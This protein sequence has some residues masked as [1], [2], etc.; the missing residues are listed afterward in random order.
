M[1]SFLDSL[2]YQTTALLSID[3]QYMSIERNLGALSQVSEEI[4][5]KFTHNLSHIILPNVQLVHSFCR[6]NG[7]EI[8]HI[9]IQSLTQD[10]R[11]RSL[12]HKRLQLHAPPGSHAAQFLPQASPKNDEIILNKTASGVFS[13]TNLSYL[14]NNL[15][16]DT[17]IVVGAYS[18]ECVSNAVRVACDEG[19][20]VIVIEDACV[21]VSTELHECSMDHLHQRYAQV[22]NTQALIDR[23]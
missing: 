8:I 3:L 23:D 1:W 2:S 16:I 7:I 10:G 4:Y 22:V 21:A 5:Q 19:Y 14:L 18:N 11:D 6:Q 17:L 9:R 12:S 13:A 20:Q 15:E